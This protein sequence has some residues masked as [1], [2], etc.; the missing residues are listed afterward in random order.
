[1]RYSLLLRYSCEIVC[2]GV[3]G[4]F[5]SDYFEYLVHV[6]LLPLEHGTVGG[7]VWSACTRKQGDLYR[8]VLEA[9]VLTYFRETNM[10]YAD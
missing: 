2:D 8:A 7:G 3:G 1:M 4:G 9:Y 6:E 5:N 10:T